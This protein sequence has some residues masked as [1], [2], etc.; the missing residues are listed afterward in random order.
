MSRVTN[1]WYHEFAERAGIKLPGNHTIAFFKAWQRAE[2]GHA[3]HNP[4]NSTL[5]WPGATDY[6]SVHVKNY[7][8]REAGV[9]ATVK[10]ISQSNFSKL[11]RAL[12]RH[13]DPYVI[14]DILDEV[15]WGTSGRLVKEVLR[16]MGVPEH[17]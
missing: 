9:N 17:G 16:S 12:R 5:P 6:N 4:W 10:I 13:E 11:L 15:P 14:A 8:N 2:G 1:Q 3:R 7:P